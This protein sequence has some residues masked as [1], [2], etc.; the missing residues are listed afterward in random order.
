MSHTCVE[1]PCEL[2]VVFF[3]ARSTL[4]KYERLKTLVLTPNTDMEPSTL[5]TLAQIQ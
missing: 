2:S 5:S 4:N 1:I 3:G